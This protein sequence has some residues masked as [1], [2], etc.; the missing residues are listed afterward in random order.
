MAGLPGKQQ[1]AL[2]LTTPEDVMIW[3]L[4]WM[5][6]KGSAAQAVAL[7]QEGTFRV[8]P[9]SALL[10]SARRQRM[11]ENIWQK[12]SLSREQFQRL[13][14][15]PIQRFAEMVQQIPASQNHHHAYPGG[16]LD[17]GLEVVAYAL[18]S[19]SPTCFH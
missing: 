8:Q 6:A 2:A 1:K 18:K 4:R 13:Y 9:A 5:K 16:M 11:L 19:G 3:P 12:T 10:G 17:H 7:P 14:L 15:A